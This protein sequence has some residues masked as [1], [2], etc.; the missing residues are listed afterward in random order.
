MKYSYNKVLGPRH[1][2]LI[3]NAFKVA[4]FIVPSKAT[5]IEKI[6]N[7]HTAQRVNELWVECEKDMKTISEKMWTFL[8]TEGM[9]EL[10]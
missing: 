2:S 7:G 10:P 4:V 6:S 8:K 5:F 3:R 9:D 1:N